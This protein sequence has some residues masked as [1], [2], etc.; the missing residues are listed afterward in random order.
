[1]SIS[2]TSAWYCP[3]VPVIK[4]APLDKDCSHCPSK[5]QLKAISMAEAGRMHREDGIDFDDVFAEHFPT[6]GACEAPYIAG[7]C[8]AHCDQSYPLPAS[9]NTH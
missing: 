5:D 1:M 2:S 8:V 6:C 4:A 7:S 3:T 9:A